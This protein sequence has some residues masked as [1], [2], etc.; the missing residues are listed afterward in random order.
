MKITEFFTSMLSESGK[1]SHKRFISIT[2][3]LMLLWVIAYCV[4]HATTDASRQEV[5]NSIMWFLGSV[6][7]ITVLPQMGS[8]IKGKPDGA[9]VVP[10][11]KPSETIT[12][13]TEVSREENTSDNQAQ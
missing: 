9:P 4:K 2:V 8:I 7:G 11:A 1:V 12:V 13:H 5:M 6:M 10:E 3:G